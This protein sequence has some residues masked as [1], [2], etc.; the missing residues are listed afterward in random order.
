LRASQSGKGPPITIPI[1][2]SIH[3]SGFKPIVHPPLSAARAL[4]QRRW[5][6]HERSRLLS[7]RFLHFN[8]AYG[9]APPVRPPLHLIALSKYGPKAVLG[10]RFDAARNH[11]Y[12]QNALPNAQIALSALYTSTVFLKKISHRKTPKLHSYTGAKRAS[13]YAQ[14][15]L[16]TPM[17]FLK[18]IVTAKRRNCTPG[19]VLPYAQIALQY[20]EKRFSVFAHSVPSSQPLF[21]QQTKN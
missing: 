6:T 19:Q 17:E 2:C 12:L 20:A 14:I 9:A 7:L 1:V 15:A 16:C 10:G 11:I 18:K 4:V 8:Y 13:M 21:F 3:R 5:P